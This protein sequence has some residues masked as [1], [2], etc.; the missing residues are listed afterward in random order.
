MNKGTYA[1][2]VMPVNRVSNLITDFWSDIENVRRAT[3]EDIQSAVLAYL[4]E[5]NRLRGLYERERDIAEQAQRDAEQWKTAAEN[6]QHSNYTLIQEV[7]RLKEE[8][9]EY[10]ILAAHFQSLLSETL[11]ELEWYANWTTWIHGRYEG[12][13]L[14]SWAV[15]DGGAR[16]KAAIQRIQEGKE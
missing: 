5:I 16:A 8:C 1:H 14:I 4:K 10:E 15:D 7:E 13:S 9:S 6:Q 3:A 12:E 11:R 2:C